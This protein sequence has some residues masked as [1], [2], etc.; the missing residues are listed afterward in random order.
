MGTRA[1]DGGGRQNRG[2]N[3]LTSQE[4]ECEKGKLRLRENRLV[5]R[6]G[7]Q[8]LRCS[9]VV[10]ARVDDQRGDQEHLEGSRPMNT[11]DPV[12]LDVR[13]GRGAGNERD[14][15]GGITSGGVQT[16]HGLRHQPDHLVVADDAQVVV[17]QQADGAA[18]LAWS[19]VENNRPCLRDTHRGRREHAIAVLGA[20]KRDTAQQESGTQQ[21]E[22]GTGPILLNWAAPPTSERSS[23]GQGILISAHPS[24]ATRGTIGRL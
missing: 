3:G 16:G 23:P 10:L 4:N 13:G 22:S 7:S 14:R 11:L 17:G 2:K 15:A 21:Q 1:R 12:K 9:S 19:A 6:K 8:E 5:S 24:R 18:A 20:G